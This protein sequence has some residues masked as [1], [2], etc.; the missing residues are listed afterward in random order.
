MRVEVEEAEAPVGVLGRVVDHAVDHTAHELAELLDELVLGHA[1]G[2]VAHV[3]PAVLQLDVHLKESGV[4]GRRHEQE[5]GDGSGA[6]DW[7]E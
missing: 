3:Q 2:D 5:A 6:G 4:R 1:L 7:Q